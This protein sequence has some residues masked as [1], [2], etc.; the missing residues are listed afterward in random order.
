MSNLLVPLQIFRLIDLKN[1][2]DKKFTDKANR[3]G[4]S[5]KTLQS[6]KKEEKAGV[7]FIKKETSRAHSNATGLALTR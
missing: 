4:Q 6:F 7:T 5:E 3:N 1:F 2:F